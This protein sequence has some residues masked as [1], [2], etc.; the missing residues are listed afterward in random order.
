MPDG[1]CGWGKKSKWTDEGNGG[2]PADDADSCRIKEP[3][4]LS[5]G[6]PGASTQGR[7]S[8][9]CTLPGSI[10]IRSAM[11]GLPDEKQD[12]WAFPLFVIL[13]QN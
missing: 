2:L 3:W 9:F 4:R 12:Y 10:W 11:A 7:T 6:F 1:S 13:E 5:H 8:V